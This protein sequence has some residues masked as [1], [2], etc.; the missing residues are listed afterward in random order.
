MSK[1]RQSPRLISLRAKN[2]KRN[3]QDGHVHIDNEMDIKMEASDVQMQSTISILAAKMAHNAINSPDDIGAMKIETSVKI[4]NAYR[5]GMIEELN[6]ADKKNCPKTD[7]VKCK[8]PVEREKK[9]KLIK[10]NKKQNLPKTA[11]PVKIIVNG[12]KMIKYPICNKKVAAKKGLK[13]HIHQVHG[14]QKPF[15]CDYCTA[16]FKT[17][18][19]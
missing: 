7:A 19:G 12:Q 9:K 8:Q 1:R 10:R 2:P 13:E 14:K 3:I 16:K 18:E 5:P 6:A 11:K 17:D 4:E 15:S